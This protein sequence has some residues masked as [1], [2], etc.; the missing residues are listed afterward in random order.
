MPDT[1]FTEAAA[2]M[3][4]KHAILGA[5]LCDAGFEVI[6]PQGGYFTV[7]DASALGGADAAAFCRA[8]PDK[9]GVVAIP[10]EAFVSAEHRG[11]YSGLV[12]FAACKR[13]EVLE[14]AARRLAAAQF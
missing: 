14:E 2:T 12:R 13:V 8:L 5:G 9:A 11:D 4:S 6:A 3:A 10:L 7:A 1:F